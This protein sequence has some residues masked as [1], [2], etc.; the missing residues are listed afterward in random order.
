[1]LCSSPCEEARDDPLSP[2]LTSDQQSVPDLHQPHQHPQ[3]S[4]L[5]HSPNLTPDWA[6]NP[7]PYSPQSLW[8]SG[9]QTCNDQRWTT[10][11][12]LTEVLIEK[13]W[14]RAKRSLENCLKSIW[15]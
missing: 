9:Y 6:G 2:V 14:I 10:I 7:T 13:S 3:H 5:D 12:N 8:G 11:N 15:R 4:S 1:M